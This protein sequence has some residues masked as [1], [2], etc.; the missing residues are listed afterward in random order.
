MGLQEIISEIHQETNAENTQKLNSMK[1]QAEKMVV[2]KM[3]QLKQHYQVESDNLDQELRRLKTKMT[4]KAELDSFREKQKLESE[5]IENLLNETYQSL[6]QTIKS[7]ENR[8]LQFLIKL[9]AESAKIIGNDS[10][11]ISLSKEDE[12][13]FKDIEKGVSV[14]LSLLPASK[15]AGGVI[16]SFEK[17][18]IDNSIENIYQKMRPESIKIIVNELK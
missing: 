1:L 14:K 15:I 13:F 4:A 11:G 10:I 16:S 7:N 9:V 5:L 6:L 17:T 3:E 8:Y 18:Y 2:A 12:K